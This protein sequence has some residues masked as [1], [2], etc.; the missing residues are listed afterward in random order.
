ATTAAIV[1]V[2]FVGIS[3]ANLPVLENQIASIR[4]VAGAP[5]SY[6]SKVKTRLAEEQLRDRLPPVYRL[7]FD[8]LNQFESHIRELLAAMDAVEA[9]T[10]EGPEAAAQRKAEFTTLV[11]AFNAK[12]PYQA[13]V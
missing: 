12:G 3:T 11:E 8:L 7:D 13:A 9:K 5:F 10:L 2:S 4:I 1:L 6:P